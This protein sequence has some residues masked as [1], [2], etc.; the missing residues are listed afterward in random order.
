M[1]SH[2]VYFF[3]SPCGH[4]STN[5]LVRIFAASQSASHSRC[6][7]GSW[8]AHSRLLLNACIIASE[9]EQAVRMC[10]RFTCSSKCH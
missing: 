10:V 2:T 6:Y 1:Y 3:Y 8:L 7:T 4:C 9:R 5:T